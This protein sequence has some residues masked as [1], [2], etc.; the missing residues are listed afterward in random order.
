MEAA[1]DYHT[2]WGK[3]GGGRQIPDDTTYVWN[4]KYDTNETI[5]KTRTDSQTQ[6]AGL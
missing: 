2:K 1:W 4:L 3:S 6:R 5:H